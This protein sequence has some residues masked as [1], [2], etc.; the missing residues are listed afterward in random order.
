MTSV[1]EG[2]KVGQRIL[3]SL[4]LRGAGASLKWRRPIKIMSS[5][6]LWCY[7]ALSIPFSERRA[8]QWLLARL[9]AVTA[10]F[11][12]DKFKRVI[13]TRRLDGLPRLPQTHNTR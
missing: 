4:D 13:N 8:F 7:R 6:A 3:G 5:L 9:R 1:Q 10:P 11:P 12:R 2:K